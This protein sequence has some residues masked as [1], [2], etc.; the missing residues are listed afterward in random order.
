[1]SLKTN[2]QILLI[3]DPVSIIATLKRD[4]F[5]CSLRQ[6]GDKDVCVPESLQC[7]HSDHDE[8]T[9][10]L[11]SAHL[12]PGGGRRLAGAATGAAGGA[13]QDRG[14]RGGRGR[15]VPV[16]GLTQ[17]DH[18]DRGHSLLRRVRDRQ[19][20]GPHC[21]PLLRWTGEREQRDIIANITAVS[22]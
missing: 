22:L 11:G 2:K 17:A 18:G 3:S 8:G 13:G 19:G 1:M 9:V 10:G 15:G 6:S 4:H 21:R 12:R 7:S 5:I 14:G 16:A 20:L